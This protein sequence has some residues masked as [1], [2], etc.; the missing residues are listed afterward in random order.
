MKLIIIESSIYKVTEK[1]YKE[2]RQKEEEIL[3]KE[4]YHRQQ[5]DF[6]DWLDSIKDKLKFIGVV[7]FD[8]RL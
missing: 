8:F 7:A 1:V 2:I 5:T 6:D 4:Y 3:K